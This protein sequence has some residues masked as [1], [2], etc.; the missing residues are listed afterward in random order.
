M[1]YPNQPGWQGSR[2]LAVT[3]GV[4]LMAAVLVAFGAQ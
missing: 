3:V 1:G 4:I 2:Q